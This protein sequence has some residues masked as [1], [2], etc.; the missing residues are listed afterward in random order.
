MDYAAKMRQHIAKVEELNKKIDD[1]ENWA[2][3]EVKKKGRDLELIPEANSK[4]R[5]VILLR[6]K[7][8]LAAWPVYANRV[9]VRNLNLA[10]AQM[11]A[12]AALVE[13]ADGS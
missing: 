6:A 5:G 4:R 11:Y 10:M 8:L 13:E 7:D 2:I 9:S 12:A 1:W 3:D